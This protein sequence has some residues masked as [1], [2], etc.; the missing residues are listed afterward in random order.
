MFG[1]MPHGCG[2]GKGA[3]KVLTGTIADGE[4]KSLFVTGGRPE[5]KGSAV[6]AEFAYA[7]TFPSTFGF[8]NR[9]QSFSNRWGGRR[10]KVFLKMESWRKAKRAPVH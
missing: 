2:E 6:L 5:L 8:G 10:A 4:L 7:G 1:S 3:S 9:I